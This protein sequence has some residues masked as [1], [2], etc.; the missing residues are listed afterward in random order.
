VSSEP[1]VRLDAPDLSDVPV[2]TPPLHEVYCT[3]F[4][5]AQFTNDPTISECFRYYS[6]ILGAVI[7]IPISCGTGLLFDEATQ[8][9]TSPGIQ[10]FCNVDPCVPAAPSITPFQP[11][12]P[13]PTFQPNTSAPS[14]SLTMGPTLGVPPSGPSN[15]T[16]R[17]PSGP[18]NPTPRPLT[19]L[20]PVSRPVSFPSPEPTLYPTRFVS[21]APVPV[22]KTFAP[23]TIGPPPYYLELPS[24]GE[25]LTLSKIFTGF[26]VFLV[27]SFG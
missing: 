4:R 7:G 19:T 11:S 2:Q 15:P 21:E 22:A 24:S 13:A 1:R 5:S 25:F 8:S 12:P 14:E 18:S 27:T 6:C 17:S 16:S 26:L 3:P 23:F 20:N 9:C 10:T